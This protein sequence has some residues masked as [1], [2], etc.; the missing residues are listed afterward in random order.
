VQIQRVLN[1]APIFAAH[2]ASSEPLTVFFL[3]L[4]EWISHRTT[5]GAVY[6]PLSGT[7]MCLPRNN[8]SIN[9]PW[10]PMHPLLSGWTENRR[11]S[12]QCIFSSFQGHGSPFM[13]KKKKKKG[14]FQIPCFQP[15]QTTAPKDGASALQ[16][17]R[18]IFP[19]GIH[20]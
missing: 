10:Q 3:S 14:L 11:N 12:V 4:S 13:K 6:H 2:A 17:H 16:H 15:T 5:E 8:A 18:A 7:P 1:H 19:S 20:R 9:P